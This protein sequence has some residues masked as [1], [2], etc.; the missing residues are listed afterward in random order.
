M[1][2]VNTELLK[3]VQERDDAYSIMSKWIDLYE[4]A[5]REYEKAIRENH[6]ALGKLHDPQIQNDELEHLV[7]KWED[8]ANEEH[9][10]RLEK[11]MEYTTRIVQR[12]S[13]WKSVSDSLSIGR[14]VFPN[15]LH[16]LMTPFKMF[17]EC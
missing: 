13:A 3:K 7:E 12:K 1:A 8:K 16:W 2:D 15:C 11:E 5:K 14:H 6:E 4:G 9:R 17:R 10:E